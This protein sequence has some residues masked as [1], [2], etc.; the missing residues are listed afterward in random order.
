L[1]IHARANAVVETSF[2]P[3]YDETGFKPVSTAPSIRFTLNPNP[4]SEL[5]DGDGNVIGNAKLVIAD[6]G[7]KVQGS[8]F[9]GEAGVVLYPNPAKDVLNVEFVIG[10][11]IG[12]TVV[13]TC[14][15]MSL[16]MFTMQGILV[17][18][19]DFSEIKPGLNKTTMD[20]RDLPNGTYMLKVTIGDNTEVTKVVVNR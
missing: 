11:D 7:F 4:L 16:Q 8:R 2:K 13:G 12:N 17:S 15:G 14:H 18:T 3:V 20:L 5:A 6:A 19:R 10:N 1:V 9:E